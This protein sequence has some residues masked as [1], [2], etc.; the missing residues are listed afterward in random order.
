VAERLFLP[1]VSS[2]QNGSGIGLAIS[3]QLAKH[4]GADLTL[5]S[6]TSIGTCFELVLPAGSS[7]PDSPRPSD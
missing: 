1:C 6:S 2:K 4:L 3:Q 5:T 7:H